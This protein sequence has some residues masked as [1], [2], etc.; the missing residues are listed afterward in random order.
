DPG[1]E[2]RRPHVGAGEA[3]PGKEKGDLGALGRYPDVAGRR[4]YGTGAG[5]GSIE[6]GDDRA[7]TLA[8]GENQVAGKAGELEQ[9]CGVS[10]EQGADDVFDVSAA[11]EAPAGTGDDDGPNAGLGVERPED[12]PQLGIDLEGECVEPV[13][14]VQ[15][16]RRD[17]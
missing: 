1:Q 17:G 15:P 7:A 2:P 6:R 10:R 14:P 13:G 5:H 12:I 16:D 3:Y 11:A 8:N 9:P 4:D